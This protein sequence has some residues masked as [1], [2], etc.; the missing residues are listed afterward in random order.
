MAEKPT[1]DRD[2]VEA[3]TSDDS[4]PARPI[5]IYDGDC[6]FCTTTAKWGQSRFGLPLIAPWQSVDLESYRLTPEE[7]G[8]A[9]QWVDLDGTV[10]AGGAA[11]AAA[12]GQGGVAARTVG[13]LS[14]LPGMKTVTEALYRVVAKN[15][16]RLPGS[17]DACRIDSVR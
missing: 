9:V 3:T 2:A 17:T 5:L 7:C 13:R 6:G 16:Y 12:L 8:T 14:Q 10:H 1:S 11:V 4:V 15:R